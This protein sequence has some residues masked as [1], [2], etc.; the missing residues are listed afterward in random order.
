MPAHEPGDDVSDRVAPPYDVISPEE[1]ERLLAASAD[2]I[3]ALELPQGPLDPDAPDNRYETGARLWSEWRETGVLST[4]DREAVY[5]LEQRYV[6][7]G[8]DVRRRCLVAAVDLAEFS[9]GVILPHERTLPRALDDRLNLTRA[10]AANLSQVFAL[11]SDAEGRTSA[12]FDEAASGEP[13]MHAT[14]ADGVLCTVWAIRDPEHLAALADIFAE[15]RL[16]IADGHHRYTTALAFRNERRASENASPDWRPHDA[17]MMAL[18]NMDDPDLVVL[19]THRVA[20][21]EGPFAPSELW[22]ALEAHFEVEEVG[23]AWPQALES[24]ERVGFVVHTPS[25]GGTRLVVLRADVDP[26]AVISGPHSPAWKRLDVA[27]L[28]ELV[29]DPYF[30]IHPDRPETLD[31][32]TFVKDAGRALVIGDHDAVFLLRPTRMDQLREV[33]L[34]GET[35]PQK[36]TYFYPKLPSGLL[37]RSLD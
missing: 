31:R 9:E 11:Y 3:V 13:V 16:F 23:D 24:L 4:D 8:R 17:I 30:G 29:L 7:E 36:S 21:T 26:T 32:L 35:M 20:D 25:D 14:D 18:A 33:A 37:M 19:P 34:A 6:L 28:Q 1:R 27:V 2:N 10:T 15:K 22:E 5:V 12:Y